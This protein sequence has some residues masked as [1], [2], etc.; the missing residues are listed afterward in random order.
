MSRILKSPGRIG[1][2][3]GSAELDDVLIATDTVGHPATWQEAIAVAM[4]NIL[5]HAIVTPL[6]SPYIEYAAHANVNGFKLD[7][8]NTPHFTDVWLAPE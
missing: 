6:L 5:Q 4:T 3:V 7:V 1:E 2:N 8:A